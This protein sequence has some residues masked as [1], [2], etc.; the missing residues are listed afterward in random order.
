MATELVTADELSAWV[1]QPIPALTA[2]LF[3]AAATALVIAETGQS[4][5]QVVGDT[6]VLDGQPEPYL[7]LPQRPVTAVSS[8]T[9]QD[10][11]LAPI[12]LDPTQYTVRGNRIWRPWGWQ[13]AAVFLPPV[14]MLGYQYLTYPPPSLITVVYDHGWAPGNQNLELARL[15]VFTLGASVFANPT[16]SRSVAVDDYTETYSDA[17]AG[18]QLPPGT[19][20]ALR[21]RY[22]HSVGSVVPR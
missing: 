18:M 4:L 19:K 2:N 10:A 6:A 20:A 8:V 7:A 13:F 15:A 12:T 11:N 9:M 17:F 3:I 21:R 14:R 1:Q 22:G 16:G 5:V